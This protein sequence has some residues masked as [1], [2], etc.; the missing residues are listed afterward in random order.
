[1]RGRG[2]EGRRPLVR[3]RRRRQGRPASLA[4]W[5][6]RS[7]PPSYPPSGNRPPLSPS[8]TH[9]RSDAHPA[10]PAAVQAQPLKETRSGRPPPAGRQSARQLSPPTRAEAGCNPAGPAELSL[11]LPGTISP[12][13]EGC[14]RAREPEGR[15]R[16]PSLDEVLRTPAFILPS[17]RRA[18]PPGREVAR[19]PLSPACPFISSLLHPLHPAVGRAPKAELSRALASRTR[20]PAS[21]SPYYRVPHRNLLP[22]SPRYSALTPKV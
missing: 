12:G 11:R 7:L 9:S 22:S 1:M 6:A 21:R 20:P 19:R 17:P 13:A 3:S 15:P 16:W 8:Q 18:W 10:R 14:R 5:L 4:G 2:P